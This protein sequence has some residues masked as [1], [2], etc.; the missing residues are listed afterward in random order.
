MKDILYEAWAR[1]RDAEIRLEVAVS[2]LTTAKRVLQELLEARGKC[3]A[4]A[5]KK[6]GKKCR[7]HTDFHPQFKRKK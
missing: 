5:G 1:Q 2:E 3:P 4:C 6:D 7:A